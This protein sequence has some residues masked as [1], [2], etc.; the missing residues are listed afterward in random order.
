LESHTA[1]ARWYIQYLRKN[2][3]L[4]LGSI[5]FTSET[6]SMKTISFTIFQASHSAI[7]SIGY[8]ILLLCLEGVGLVQLYPPS[9]A[10]ASASQA[11]IVKGCGVEAPP[12]TVWGTGGT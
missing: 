7:M 12:S 4:Q 8:R 3:V 11:S 5:S 9:A 1:N 10:S 2:V 6:Y